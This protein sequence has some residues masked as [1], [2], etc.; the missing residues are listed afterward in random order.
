MEQIAQ[1]RSSKEKGN[2]KMKTP[3]DEPSITEVARSV[4]ELQSQM[5]SQMEAVNSR[6][7]A[8]ELAQ[9]EFSVRLAHVEENISAIKINVESISSAMGELFR[10]LVNSKIM[11]EPVSSKIQSMETVAAEQ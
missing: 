4:T 5:E 1:K 11:Q 10:Q 6:L 8:Q 2:D 3:E 9:K 7:D